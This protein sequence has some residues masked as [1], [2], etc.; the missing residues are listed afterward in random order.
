MIRTWQTRTLRLSS[1]SLSDDWMSVCCHFDDEPAT[2]DTF[3]ANIFRL[4]R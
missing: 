1:S 3:Y 4:V 2:V